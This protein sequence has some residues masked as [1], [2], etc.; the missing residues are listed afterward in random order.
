MGLEIER[1]FLVVNDTYK[2]MAVSR[3]HIEQFYLSADPDRT[4]RVRI[5]DGH[6]WITVKGLTVG[7]RRGEWEYRIPVADAEAMR[8]MAVRRVVRKMRWIVP[9]AEDGLRWEVDIFEGELDG[10][11]VAEIEL[12]SED[13]PFTRAPFTGREVTGE[14]GYYNSVLALGGKGSLPPFE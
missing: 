4:V 12:P 3:R 5:A 1:K 6:A 8:P 13:T 10:L 14:P 9:A 11:R 2:D 7:C